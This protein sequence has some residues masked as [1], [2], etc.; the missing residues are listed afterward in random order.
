MEE[1]AKFLLQSLPPLDTKKWLEILQEQRANAT[2][3]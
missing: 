1:A 3:R 2:L